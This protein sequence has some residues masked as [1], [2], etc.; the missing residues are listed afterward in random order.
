M[1]SALADRFQY[2]PP[3]RNVRSIDDPDLGRLAAH[4]PWF[5][6]AEPGYRITPRPGTSI[7]GARTSARAA[8]AGA[9]RDDGSMDFRQLPL[10]AFWA[11][12]V[13][14]ADLARTQRGD[15]VTGTAVVYHRMD[16]AQGDQYRARLTDIALEGSLTDAVDRTRS[17]LAEADAKRNAKKSS[18]GAEA[19]SPAATASGVPGAPP[20]GSESSPPPRDGGPP[21]RDGAPPP[22]GGTTPPPRPGSSGPP[23]RP[24]SSGPPPLPGSPPPR[25]DSPPP[26]GR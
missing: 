23:P 9:R 22:R 13:N 8:S 4:V 11:I 7:I 14:N 18:K 6:L 25:P 15:E 19:A 26:R 21:P 16:P 2:R 20:R 5:P 12:T 10:D 3:Q 24:G 1:D 17:G